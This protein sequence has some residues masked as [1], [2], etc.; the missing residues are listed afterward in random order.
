MGCTNA[1]K[2]AIE[3]MPGQEEPF[4]ERFR[5]IAPPLV[6]EVRQHI[7]E[8]LDGGAIRPSQSA[9]AMPSCSLG[10]RTGPGDFV[11]I[12]ADST[13]VLRKMLTP[14]LV[15]KRPWSLLLELAIS[16]ACVTRCFSP[17]MGNVLD[18]CKTRNYRTQTA[19]L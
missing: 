16:R 17:L 19:W 5:R 8:M 2:H 13:P 10:R 14:F 7:Q 3:L 9:G 18:S 6:D 4:K 1:T 12:F 11:S 15:S